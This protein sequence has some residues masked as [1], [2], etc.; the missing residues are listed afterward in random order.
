MEL[1]IAILSIMLLICL[2]LHAST[3]GYT[4]STPTQPTA[5]GS[6]STVSNMSS[7]AA[8]SVA[9]P[10]TTTGTAPVRSGGPVTIGSGT[11]NT[12]DLASG[13]PLGISTLNITGT[14]YLNLA[15]FASRSLRLNLMQNSEVVMGRG[16]LISGNETIPVVAS[17][18]LNDNTLDFFVMPREIMD[19][20]D[21]PEHPRKQ[22]HWK[23]WSLS[24]PSRRPDLER[25]GLG[26]PQPGRISAIFK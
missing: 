8:G 1:K 24:L 12:P 15:D 2:A 6:S 21:A 20:E 13:V 14:V 11:V 3:Q 19:L 23:L 9:T 4:S 10:I 25:R 17:G 16:S 7:S 22:R 26:H 5:L 18:A